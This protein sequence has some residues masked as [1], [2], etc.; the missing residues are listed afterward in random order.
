[1]LRLPGRIPGIV[2]EWSSTITRRGDFNAAPQARN[3]KPT[4]KVCAPSLR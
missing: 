1:M 3:S 2:P 4:L